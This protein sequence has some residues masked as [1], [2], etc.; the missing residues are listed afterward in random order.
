MALIHP[1]PWRIEAAALVAL[2]LPM[3][4]GNIAWSAIAAT[5]LLLLG[6]LGAEAV[7]AGA[8]AINLFHALLLFGM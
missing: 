1:S 7:A 5:D 4:A 6:R 2:A 3:I 8:L